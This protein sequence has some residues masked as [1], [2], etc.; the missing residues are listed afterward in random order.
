MQ[1]E[2]KS[3]RKSIN[4][5]FLKETVDRSSFNNFKAEL[6][7]LLKNIDSAKKKD[8]HEEHFKNLLVPFLNEVG[9]DDYYI[10][11]SVR[12]D[13]A[14]HTDGKVKDP[15]GVLL[16][17]KRPS[18]KNEMI[19]EEDFN[20]KA[21]HEAVLYYLEQ[22]I[23]EDNE[24][25]KH[26][27]ITD[28][29]NWFVFDAQE[30]ERC[31][32][33]PSAL[34]KVYK[35][36][37][38][39]QKVSSNKDFMY[40][41][42]GDF[43]DSQD[44]T[45]RGLHLDLQSY[46]KYLKAKE[47]SEPEKKL[48][49]LFKFFS[50]TQLLKE[51]FANDSNTLNREFYRELLYILGLEETTKSNTRYIERASEDK[52]H[53]GS[54][55]ENTIRIL[56][57]EDHLSTVREPKVKYGSDRDEQLF[58]VALEL[59]I[60]WMNRVLFLKLL[61][62]QLF[63]YHRQDKKF[64][65]LKSKTIDGYDELNKLFFQVLARREADRTEDINEKFGHIPYLNSSLFDPSSLEHQSVFIS[66]LDDK[67]TLPVYSKSVLKDRRG[68]EIN[69]LEYLF[70]FLDAYDFAAEGGEE[71]QEEHKSLIN[72]SVLGLIFEKINGYKDGSYFTPGFIT[73]YMA[74]ETLR[75][76]VTDKFAQHWDEEYLS[77]DDIYNRI[78]RADTDIEKANEIVNSITICDPAVGSGHF[79]VSC[80]NEL[81][82]IKSDLGILTDRDGKR[83]RDVKVEVENDEL[84][85]TYSDE[86][87][88]EY[89]VSHTWHGSHLAKRKISAN[90]QR[91]QKAL[92]HEKRHIIENCLFGVD[93]NSNSV[94]ICRLRLWIELLKN[95]YYTEKS[96]YHELEVLPNI[97]INIKTGNS[98][99]SRFDLDSDLSSVFKDSDHSLQDYKEAVHSYKQTGDRSEKKRLQKLIN[100]IKDEYSTTLLNNDPIYE[101]LSKQRGRLD[102]MQNADL[103][104]EKKF[105][106]KDIK[107]QEKKVKKV[108]KEIEEQESGVFYNQAF[109]WRFEFPEVL[110]KEG[111]FTGFDVVIGN[112]PYVPSKSASLTDPLKSY[113]NSEYSTT[114][115]Q[116]NTFG[117]FIELGIRLIR[118]L[119]CYS[120]IVPNYWL[121]TRYDKKLRNHIFIE[122]TADKLVNV[123][124]VF[125]DAVV[126][127]LLLFGKKNTR[128]LPKRI[129]LLSLDEKYNGNSIKEEVD[130][131][132]IFDFQEIRIIE[133]EDEFEQLTFKKRLNLESN[134]QLGNFFDF[135]FGLKPYQVG[136]GNPPQTQEDVNQKN[137]NSDSQKTEDHKQFL[138]AK[139]VDTL[140]VKGEIEF[141]KYGEHLAEPRSMDLFSGE[142][143]VL[144]R[145]ISGER[146]KAIYLDDEILCNTDLITLKPKRDLS[147]DFVRFLLGIVVSQLTKYYL[148][149]TNINL[150]RKAYPKINTK[151]LKDFPIPPYTEN[152]VKNISRAVEKAQNEDGQKINY[153]AEIDRMVYKV[154]GLD[155][156]DVEIVEES[157]SS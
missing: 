24:D 57:A 37:K 143:I 51:P 15:V 72:A 70:E 121:S 64:K 53:P 154:Y 128:N 16:E 151:T 47:D 26:I 86:E 10:N 54:F 90:R 97:D 39:D 23:E 27:V 52:R 92:F 109:E 4:K 79:L 140:A 63:R 31:Y 22:R 136:K 67:K 142:R 44:T 84:I 127:T 155:E 13:L 150:D 71:I 45:L 43:I 123:H 81:L 87:L 46:E 76:A 104:G 130:S 66:N 18:N 98:L 122:N 14:I 132:S 118:K 60:I 145:I 41:K 55:I 69:T 85:V 42:I 89:D 5:A 153:L 83:L 135:S 56:D 34:K 25:L 144:G 129:E 48:I 125:E 8:E 146:I 68:D 49:P 11:T 82:A 141:L 2:T 126:E 59:S 33:R 115:Y 108:E 78:G 95:T 12:I 7:Q 6:G 131:G 124:S 139:N 61:E 102:L 17:V 117:L 134:N 40:D 106:K 50:P 138:K 147:A 62:A 93:I 149:S 38:T 156:E 120:M 74:R 152:S 116:L 32:Y 101:K 35:S 94:K 73:E 58:N 137:Y 88:F 148:I 21:M 157:V 80:L 100:N 114:E 103:F 75:K 30:F 65:F 96:D 20:R 111:Q 133:K 107:K 110:N 9:F 29:L 28:T 19:T 99:V 1:L 113:Y 112:P 91:I 105:S 36:W 77:F 3:L 119:G